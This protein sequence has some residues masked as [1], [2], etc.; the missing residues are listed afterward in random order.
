MSVSPGDFVPAPGQWPV[1]PQDDVPIR[2]DR[3]WD[4]L[5]KSDG[6]GV[7]HAGAMLQ[8]RRLGN[9]LYVGVH[10]DE[11]ILENKGPTVMTL[12]ERV[13]AVEACRWATRCIPRAPYVT[14]LSWVSHYGC[15]YVVHGDDITSDSNG[16]DCYRFV[17]AAGR[18]RVVKRTPGISTTDLVGRMLLCTKGHFIKSV[19]DTLAGVEGS[20]NQEERKQFGVELMQRI[21]DYATDESGLRPG[22]QV[23]TWTG[24]R[25][26]KVSDTVEEA[27]T[28]E[29]LVNGKAIKPGQRVVYVDG[30]FDLFSSGHIE[31][32]RQVLEL[33]EL[34]GRQRGWY[35]SEQVEKRLHE[36][37]EDYSP[38]YVVAGIHDDD[39]INNWKG[40]NYPIMNIFERGLCVLQ[41]RYIHAVIF[42]APFSPSQPYLEAMPFGVPD[43][44]YHGP[45]TFIP[46]T[47]DPYTAPKRMGIFRQI[48]DHPFQHV[49]A[50]EIVDRILRSREAYEERQRAKLQKAIIEEQVKSEEKS[51]AGELG[52]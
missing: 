49:N 36:F 5:I 32:L 11:A 9:E 23:W 51:L 15:K 6:A 22:P 16:E 33:E 38:A 28:F 12:K 50:G 14:S 18:F 13:A 17:K 10:S 19:K 24:S 46:L 4:S 47:Y 48:N 35:D 27:G 44:V 30:G 1:D 42:S 41:C 25:P 20:D 37:G 8:A 39:V 29:T 26:A 2:E 43:V 7:G 52:A 31:F 45:T 40:F 21:R 3:I 34:E